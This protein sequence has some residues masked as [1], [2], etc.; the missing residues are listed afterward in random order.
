MIKRL[1]YRILLDIYTQYTYYKNCFMYKSVTNPLKT[2]ILPI[3]EIK[4]KLY[5]SKLMIKYSPGNI[6]DGDW[7][8]GVKEIKS[9]YEEN[10]KHKGL[11]EHFKYGVP[12]E[13][14]ILFRERYTRKLKEKGLFLGCASLEEIAKKYKE[15][16]DP[17]YISIKKN[18]FTRR[19]I[20]NPHIDPLYLHI[21]RNGDFIYT[22][23]GNHRLSIAIILGI[24]ELPFR[25]WLRHKNW[26]IIRDKLANR[27][28][29]LE[30][31]FRDHPDL[32]DILRN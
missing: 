2:L 6:I 16:I 28:K 1:K 24:K 27:D 25:I 31:K 8:L 18:G 29:L 13:D 10:E 30:T 32:Q 9:Y 11:V 5:N 3:S 20:R 17:L 7:D 21:G 23:G 26:Q 4:Y 12:W 14:T 22:T 15:N 19:S